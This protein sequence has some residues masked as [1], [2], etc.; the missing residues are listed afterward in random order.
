MWLSS[1]KKQGVLGEVIQERVGRLPRLPPVQVAGVIFDSGA[2]PHFLD[3][4]DIIV[5]ALLQ[6]LGL[7]ELAVGLELAEPLGEFFL[8]RLGGPFQDLL[9][10][11]VMASRKKVEVAEF[12]KDPPPKRVDFRDGIDQVAEKLHPD[13]LVFLI[14]GKDLDHV[15]ADPEGAAMKVVV[16]ALVLDFHQAGQQ[17]VTGDLLL[18]LHQHDHALVGFRRAQAVNTGDGGH[19]DRVPAGENRMSGRMAHL[20][21]EVVDGGVFFNICVRGGDVGFRLVIIVIADKIF[22][23]V[24]G[25]EG[26][27]LLKKLGGQ[28]FIGSDHQGRPLQFRDHVGHGERLP[29]TGYPEKDLMAQPFPGPVDK[30]LNGPGLIALGFEGGNDFKIGH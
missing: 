8:D 26:A 12:L 16:V 2:V 19:D 24:F 20:V 17:V 27:E 28:G 9:G 21:D 10:G 14:G 6:A 7:Q 22:H 30:L 18:I 1:N 23:G 4:L 11:D 5:R 25:E 15:A 29:R 13:G 3:H